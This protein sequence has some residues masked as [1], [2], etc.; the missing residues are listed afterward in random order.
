MKKLLLLTLALS[1]PLAPVMRAENENDKKKHKRQAEAAAE[2]R[3]EQAATPVRQG[4]RQPV[5]PG[6]SGETEAADIAG[7]GRNLRLDQDDVKHTWL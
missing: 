6:A 3:G 7:I 5:Q 1:L 4:V 2:N